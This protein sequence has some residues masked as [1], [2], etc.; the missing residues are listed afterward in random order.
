MLISPSLFASDAANL[1]AAVRLAEQEGA[2]RL[3]I[4]VMDGRFVPNFSFGPNIVESIRPLT[5]LPLEVHL[6]VNQPETHI[7]E[8]IAAGADQVTVHVEATDAIKQ[9][10]AECRAANVELGLA[11]SPD[12]PLADIDPWAQFLDWLLVMTIYPG[13]GG[14]PFIHECVPR[15]ASA[16]MRR[17]ELGAHYRLSVD[18]GINAHTAK[19]CHDAGAD[20]VVAGSYLFGAPSMTDAMTALRG[21]AAVAPCNRRAASEPSTEMGAS[22]GGIGAMTTRTVKIGSS[23]GLHARP[24]ALF[25]KAVNEGAVPVTICR[26]G[27]EP[28]PANSMLAIMALGAMHGDTVELSCDAEGAE[29]VLD[30]LVS[31]LERDL[32]SEN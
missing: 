10:T 17:A 6:M 1:G 12:T 14:Q 30:A 27:G 20:L 22:T 25:V 4:D 19:L 21:A 15:I 8:F 18:G 3:H 16:K 32:D 26:P 13:L 24:A 7:G 23:V 31:L 2:D 29:R 28:A 5:T 11:I 9:I